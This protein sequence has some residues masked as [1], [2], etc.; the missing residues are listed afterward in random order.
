M[1]ADL[2]QWAWEVALWASAAIVLV[3]PLRWVLGRLF[4][5]RTSILAWTLVPLVCAATALPPRTV[6]I[7]VPLEA[8]PAMS[9]STVS[10]AATQ[11]VQ[12]APQLLPAAMVT[13]WVVGA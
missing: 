5:L 13:A 2:M 4:G 10:V 1:S 6:E 8:V 7:S 12:P 3:V 9:A 11:S